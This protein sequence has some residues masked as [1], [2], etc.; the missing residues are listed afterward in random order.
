MFLLSIRILIASLIAAIG[1]QNTCPH[2]WEGK[3]AFI[4]SYIFHSCPLKEHKH[5]EPTGGEHSGKELS[6]VH[7]AFVFHVGKP[8][9]M[10]QNPTSICFDIPFVSDSILEVFSDPLL[11]PPTDH[12]FV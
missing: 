5:S 9:A 1:I 8:V 4:S 10:A 3:S 2:G 6:H 7:P 12:L 11:K